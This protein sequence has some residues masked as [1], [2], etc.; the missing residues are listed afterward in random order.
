MFELLNFSLFFFPLVSNKNVENKE[1]AVC[2]NKFFSL[3]DSVWFVS[4][5]HSIF[6]NI[7]LWAIEKLDADFKCKCK[8]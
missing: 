8:N 7:T 2:A 1:I 6:Q 5:S 4:V 3:F